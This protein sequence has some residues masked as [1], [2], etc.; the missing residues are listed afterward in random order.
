[1]RKAKGL[2]SKEGLLKDSMTLAGTLSALLLIFLL[3]PHTQPGA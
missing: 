2:Q 1:M 3:H